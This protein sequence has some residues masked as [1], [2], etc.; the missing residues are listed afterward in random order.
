MVPRQKHC[1]GHV[2]F[3]FSCF[4]SCLASRSMSPLLCLL[5][6][7]PILHSLLV[8]SLH[9]LYSIQLN[10][11]SFLPPCLFLSF[12]YLSLASSSLF[13][14]FFLL[15]LSPSS[16]KFPSL[17]LWLLCSYILLSFSSQLQGTLWWPQVV[18]GGICSNQIMEDKMERI[19]SCLDEKF[20]GLGIVVV[21]ISTYFLLVYLSTWNTPS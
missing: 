13:S 2:C 4:L 5:S 3:P 1:S 12:T 17:R 7:L 20:L 15:F 14:F 18:T 8:F 16:I 21:N 6:L 19:V 10:S 9:N 11:N